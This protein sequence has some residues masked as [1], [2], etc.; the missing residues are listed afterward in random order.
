VT[1]YLDVEAPD[2]PSAAVSWRP[3]GRSWNSNGIFKLNCVSLGGLLETRWKWLPEILI[4]FHHSLDGILYVQ[5]RV[6]YGVTFGHEFR[7]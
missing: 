3:H 6:V 4:E 1:L 7:E 5:Q 2:S